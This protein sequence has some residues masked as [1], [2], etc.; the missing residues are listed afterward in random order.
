M[1]NTAYED[2]GLKKGAIPLQ[3][4]LKAG[5][6]IRK[7]RWYNHQQLSN[8]YVFNLGVMDSPYKSIKICVN[9]LFNVLCI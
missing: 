8:Q 5:Y 9:N 6:I 3:Q 4:Y 7:D 2:S 1:L